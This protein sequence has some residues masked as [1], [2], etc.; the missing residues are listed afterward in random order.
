MSVGRR[1]SVPTRRSS[2]LTQVARCEITRPADERSVVDD[3]ELG[4]GFWLKMIGVIFLI[5]IGGLIAIRKITPIIFSQNPA[6]SS[7]SD[8]KSTRLNSSHLGISY[9]VF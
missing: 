4:A 9:A 3:D 7:S 2:E 6:P 1:D 8:R 5:G